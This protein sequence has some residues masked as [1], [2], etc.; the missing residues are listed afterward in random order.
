MEIQSSTVDELI[1]APNWWALFAEYAAECGNGGIGKPDMQVDTYR[2]LESVGALKI[3]A[4]HHDGELIGF[5]VYLLSVLPHYGKLVAI[6][7]SVFVSPSHRD[8]GAGL[9]LL[10]ATEDAALEAGA[11]GL[12]VS[13]PV[14]GSFDRLLA[15]KRYEHTNAV[16]F[17]RLG[18]MAEPIR[19][20]P[21]MTDEAI[22]KSRE[23]ENRML[24]MPQINLPV[25]HAL[26]A[27]MYHRTITIPAGVALTGALIKIPTL[28]IVD[29]DCEVFTGAEVARLTGHNVLQCQPHRKQV[30]L[31]HADTHLTMIF[32]T[33]AK[34]VEEAENEFTDDAA[35]LQSRK[36]NVCLE[37]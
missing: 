26:H 10:K 2:T 23:T 18:A 17:K 9:A 32:Q 37:Q 12:L 16:Y 6:T 27:G 1:A 11:V 33:Q 4:A 35:R 14:G 29:G 8:C 5:V 31:A 34:T 30:F 28:L 7:E 24:A 20:L 13:A 15:A 22:G 25:S 21:A 19:C 3:N 36:E